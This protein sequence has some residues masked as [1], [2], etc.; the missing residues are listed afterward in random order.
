MEEEMEKTPQHS[1]SW[2]SGEQCVEWPQE[3]ATTFRLVPAV[4]KHTLA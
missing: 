1:N 2:R 3:G 4:M